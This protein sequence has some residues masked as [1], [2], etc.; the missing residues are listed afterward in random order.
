[1]KNIYKIVAL[2]FIGFLTN[3]SESTVDFVQY[4]TLTGR[5]VKSNSY[6]PIENAKVTINP[7]NNA[8]F[9]DAD[10][11]FT[12][13]DVEV[14]DYSVGASKEGYL[15]N[16]QPATVA[17][18]QTVNVIFEM[19]D[20]NSLNR[21]P[22]TPTLITPTD[23]SENQELSVE[24]VWS[25]SDPDEDTITYGLELKNDLNDDVISV[26]N[27][28]DT[29]YV[30]SNLKYGAKYFWQVSATDS[31]N[32]AVL[33]EVS[34]F[35]T[36]ADPQNRYFYVQ[37]NANGNNVIYSASY[38]VAN[39]APENIVQL[40]SESQNS[41]RPRKNMASDLI[42]FLKT[43]NN[44]THLFTMNQDG[45]NEQQVTSAVSVATANL[46]EVDYAWSSNG[47]YLLYPHYD[48][49]YKINKDGSGLQM[50]YQ[51]T[52]GSYITECDWSHDGS[53]IALKTNDI[54][55]YNVAIY[56]IDM[57]G[58]VTNNV[59]SGVSGAAGGLNISVD[60]KL[61]IY[62]YDV[63]GYENADNRQLQS[64]IFKYEFA[65]ST[66]TD[67]S[68]GNIT[69]GTNDLDPRLSPNEANVIFVNTSNDGIST[70][71]ILTLDIGDG[72]N[73]TTLFTD[74]FM[75]DWE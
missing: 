8:V 71:S 70:K 72:S 75:P 43:Y 17:A 58:N 74:A 19:D 1:M 30:V 48:K 11:Y 46:N 55:G 73:R 9:S 56:T 38:S 42:A 15:A 64:H 39:T 37:K 12:M 50:V 59:L 33:S 61:L 23:G 62:T 20:D 24:L 49:L 69:S 28:T 26:A 4:G 36:K 60:N 54:S 25:S 51:T 6:E 53:M 21:P 29:T 14:G 34:V 22:L 52:D 10:G 5:V 66:A 16:F 2:F 67:L 68:D 47:N 18:D 3:C 32:D 65:T 41:W 31:I 27:L 57:N 45:S 63:S 44:E 35:K 13:T 40:T 7:T